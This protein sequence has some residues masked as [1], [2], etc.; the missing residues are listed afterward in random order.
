MCFSSPAPGRKRRIKI[1][2]TGYCRIV[3]SLY[4]TYFMPPLLASRNFFELRGNFRYRIF[5]NRNL[6]LLAL[7]FEGGEWV[8]FLPLAF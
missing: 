3:G 1:R 6:Y 4:G 8:I 5:R 7:R 2:F